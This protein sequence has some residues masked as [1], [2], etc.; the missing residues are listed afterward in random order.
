MK[1]IALIRTSTI[2][3]EVETQKLEIENAI[4]KNNQNEIIVI[5]GAGASAIKLDDQ[6]L[7]NIQQ[8]YNTMER[9]DVVWAWAIDRIGRNEEVLM[10]FKNRLI[11]EGVNLVILNPSLTLLNPDGTVNAGVELA[12]SLFSTMAKQEMEMKKERFKR[13][14]KRNKEAGQYVGGRITGGYKVNPDTKKFEIDETIPIAELFEEYANTPVSIK[15]LAIKYESFFDRSSIRSLASYI[16]KI[17]RNPVYKGDAVF[18][19]IISDEVFDLVQNKLQNFRVLPRYHY[20]NSPFWLK[21]LMYCFRKDGSKAL[22]TAQKTKMAYKSRL[23]T[24]YYLNINALDSLVFHVLQQVFKEYNPTQLIEEINAQNAQIETKKQSLEKE[25][26]ILFEKD[27]ELDERYFITCSVKNYDSLKN[28]LHLKIKNM[29]KEINDLKPIEINFERPTLEGLDDWQV[30]DV[31]NRYISRIYVKKIEK[32]NYQI[33]IITSLNV[34][35]PLLFRSHVGKWDKQYEYTIFNGDAPQWRPIPI[36]RHFK[37]V[38][39]RTKKLYD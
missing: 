26:K 1:N 38:N 11:K 35:V 18:P 24:G 33:D 32:R 36:I 23:E 39:R 27:A 15:G 34:S 28:T 21:G 10:S 30:K 29:Q 16:Q 3:Q 2:K 14:K 25:L 6:Y 7:A 5:G 20:E 8:V 17:L 37:A 12:F 13:G 31:F 22:L 9:G 19:R 4:K